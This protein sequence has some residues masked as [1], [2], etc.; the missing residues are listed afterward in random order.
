MYANRADFPNMD[1]NDRP[2]AWLPSRWIDQR[3][4][5]WCAELM[6]DG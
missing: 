1:E 3:R 5:L 2:R 6:D 4:I